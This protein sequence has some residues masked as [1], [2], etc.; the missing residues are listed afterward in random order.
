MINVEKTIKD[1]ERI[2]DKYIHG[3]DDAFDAE[4]RQAIDNAILLLSCLTNTGIGHP[5]FERVQAVLDDSMFG[6][7]RVDGETYNVYLARVESYPVSWGR[8]RDCV[9]VYPIHFRHKFTLIER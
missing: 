6:T 3:G 9:G 2:K 8:P 7:I 1:L 5:L 4:R